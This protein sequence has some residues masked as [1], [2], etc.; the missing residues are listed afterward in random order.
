MRRDNRGSSQALAIVATMSVA[1][2][3]EGVAIGE[4]FPQVRSQDDA[5][6]VAEIAAPGKVTLI[7]FWATWCSSCKSELS[8]MAKLFKDLRD[9]PRVAFRFVS[10]DKDPAKAAAW[11]GENVVFDQPRELLRFDAEFAA[12]EALDIESFPVTYVVAPDATVRAIH[13][14]YHEGEGSVAA[15]V[16]EIRS[17][18]GG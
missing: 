9:H 11:F 14:G 15:M 7:N 6:V 8:E 4:K 3:C 18:L 10:V 5:G 12:A 17:L 13:W 2:V 16:T 1:G